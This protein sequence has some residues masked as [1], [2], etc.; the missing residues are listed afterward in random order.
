MEEKRQLKGV[1]RNCK[2]PLFYEEGQQV[3]HC[4]YCEQDTLVSEMSSVN[5]SNAATAVSGAAAIMA[6]IDNA[7]S[8]LAY[9]ENFFEGFNWDEFNETAELTIASVDKMVETNLIKG[10]ANPSTWE[11]Q[12]KSIAT[13]LLKKVEGLKDLEAKFLKVYE[14]SVDVTEGLRIFDF[15]ARNSKAI[16]SSK[17][18]IV[19]KLE[20][21][22]TFAKKYS[23]K[24]A[25]VT[26]LQTILDSS[27]KP[28]LDS[29]KEVESFKDLPGFDKAEKNK[30]KLVADR[31]AKKGI[32]AEE[33]Y[34]N[35]VAAFQSG[36]NTR[37]TLAKFNEVYGYKDAAKY[38]DALNVWVR[39]GNEKEELIKLGNKF[40]ILRDQ[41][42]TE[43]SINPL[44]KGN[45]KGKKDKAPAVSEEEESALGLMRKEMLEVVD[46]NIA[47]TPVVKDITLILT[48]YGSHM[49]YIKNNRTICSYNSLAQND[50]VK[51]HIKAKPG[52]FTSVSGDINYYT[53]KNFLFLKQ[54]LAAKLQKAGCVKKLFGK[55][56]Q[57]IV[58]DNNY[59]V[60]AIDLATN[61]VSTIIPEIIDIMDVYGEEIFFLKAAVVDKIKRNE[62]YAY[63][64][65]TK[66]TRKVLSQDNEIASVVD[67]KVIYM[68]WVPNQYNKN[69][70]ALDF[71][72][73]ESVLLEKNIYN[74]FKTLNNK[75]Y[76]VVGNQFN[77]T[78]FCINTDGTD[79]VEVLQTFNVCFEMCQDGEY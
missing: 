38:Y 74:F 40:Y 18:A 70:Y 39:F 17:E 3:V 10:A 71:K 73:G 2:N 61:E 30:Q 53:Y 59:A 29:V 24:P 50:A 68:T 75:V 20:L 63:N 26:E 72:T 6:S 36:D 44:T 64:V 31:L 4:M 7:D 60:T 8:A 49:F 52:D 14:E 32:N 35:A 55:K 48:H 77:K 69:L 37:E 12:F 46:G 19:K 51:E 43:I 21:A 15:Y 11:L 41:K 78:L 54:K 67:G 76:Y 58:S 27:V 57:I 13:P 5:T 34:N 79:R 9:L 45:G 25:L 33:V 47:S 28:A 16:V 1:C 56:D 65:F 66:E 62:F 42:V 22:I 23:A